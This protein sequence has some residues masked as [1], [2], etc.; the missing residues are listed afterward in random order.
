MNFVYFI[1]FELENLLPKNSWN[2]EQIFLCMLSN[3][4]KF[5]VLQDRYVSHLSLDTW[6][7]PYPF[8]FLSSFT[9]FSLIILFIYLFI[10]Q[11]S[12]PY[13]CNALLYSD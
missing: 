7:P 1:E 8:M 2:V 10:Y 9:S 4:M 11:I 3:C 6:I 13:N 5:Y 12:S